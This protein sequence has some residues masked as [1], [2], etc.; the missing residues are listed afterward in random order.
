MKLY[1]NLFT[2]L[3]VIIGTTKVSSQTKEEITEIEQS[4]Q[5][6]GKY[7]LLVMKAQHLKAAIQTGNELKDKSSKIDF[8]ILVCGELVKEIST[9]IILQNFI[10]VAINEN[11]LKIVIC[12]LSIEQ[13]K[14]DQALLPTEIPITKNGFVYMF[15]L[16]ENGYQSI[17]L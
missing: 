6:N 10:K 14:V 17:I 8:Q 2:V 13:F 15:G 11:S 16:Q 7:A 3:F 4:I 5:K 12:G 9:D 1:I